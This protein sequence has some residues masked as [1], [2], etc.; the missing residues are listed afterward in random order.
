MNSLIYLLSSAEKL[1]LWSELH[2]LDCIGLHWPLCVKDIAEGT[3]FSINN[4]TR[5][6]LGLIKILKVG[7]AYDFCRDYGHFPLKL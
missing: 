1:G 7:M 3:F 5:I 2:R 4:I 6:F